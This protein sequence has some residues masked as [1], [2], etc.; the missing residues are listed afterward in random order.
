MRHVSAWEGESM[1]YF[2]FFKRI[3]PDITE[4]E[5][6]FILWERTPFPVAYPKPKEIYKAFTGFKRACNNK[7]RLCD[8]CHNKA[9]IGNLCVR[10][11]RALEKAL[12]KNDQ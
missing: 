1:T 11:K 6:E 3:K 7:I 2:D 10:C 9:V 5:V 12:K 8:C 4:A